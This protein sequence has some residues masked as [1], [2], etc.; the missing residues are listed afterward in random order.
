MITP[1][2]SLAATERVLPKI[3][4]DFTTAG[5]WVAAGCLAFAVWEAFKHEVKK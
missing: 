2:F 1:S 4:L 5:L 3:A